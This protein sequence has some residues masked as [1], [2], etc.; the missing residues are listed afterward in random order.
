MSTRTNVNSYPCQL[1]PMSTRTH[2]NSYHHQMSARTQQGRYQ[3]MV[4]AD[5]SYNTADVNSYHHW[6]STRTKYKIILNLIIEPRKPNRISHNDRLPPPPPPPL[7]DNAVMF[8]RRCNIVIT[9]REECIFTLP[10]DLRHAIPPML[11]V[12]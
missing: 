6:M 8:I 3:I 11:S 12:Y 1:V 10:C 9:S 4:R 2:V 5:I 7:P